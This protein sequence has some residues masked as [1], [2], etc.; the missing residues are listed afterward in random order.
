L[1]NSAAIMA[2][3]NANKRL[4]AAA[5]NGTEHRRKIF[6]THWPVLRVDKQPIVPAVGQL[7]SYRDAMGVEEQPDL[8]Y[9]RAQL[10]LEFRTAGFSQAFFLLIFLY[11]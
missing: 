7:F 4:G 9:P 10:L 3:R 6:R 8:R 1:L 5:A 2:A 11:Q